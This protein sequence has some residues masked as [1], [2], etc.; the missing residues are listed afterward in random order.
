MEDDEENLE[1]HMQAWPRA[2]GAPAGAG[3]TAGAGAAGVV[4]DNNKVAPQY[5][6]YKD[7]P[8]IMAEACSLTAL[9]L[10]VG[11]VLYRSKTSRERNLKSHMNIARVSFT[12]L[13]PSRSCIGR[14][15]CLRWG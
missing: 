9:H 5:I 1:T 15:I 14:R 8:L 7:V 13:M 4:D 3:A 6:L 10:I 11:I 2:V 12:A